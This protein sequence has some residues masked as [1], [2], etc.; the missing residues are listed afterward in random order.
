[1]K[2]DSD[3]A[4][5]KYSYYTSLRQPYFSINLFF[6]DSSDKLVSGSLHFCP[7]AFIIP[8]HFFIYAE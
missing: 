2:L 6:G 8:M 7:E 1:M 5:L 4:M 3:C